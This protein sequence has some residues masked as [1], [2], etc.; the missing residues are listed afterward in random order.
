[1]AVL[2]MFAVHP[3]FL[4]NEILPRGPHGR[5]GF[6]I[7]RI[8]DCPSYPN[9][10]GQFP[11][12]IPRSFLFSHTSCICPKVRFCDLLQLLP[13]HGHRK[14]GYLPEEPWTAKANNPQILSRRLQHPTNQLDSHAT[15]Q[16]KN[17]RS[18]G[19][20]ITGGSSMAGGRR[21]KYV[22]LITKY[23]DGDQ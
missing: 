11:R 12:L 19:Y 8:P 9:R 13:S 3:N 20:K 1:M 23:I 22:Y 21:S 6:K 2:F 15:P 10:D 7:A 18:S 4:W 16:V 17:R 5:V 14:E